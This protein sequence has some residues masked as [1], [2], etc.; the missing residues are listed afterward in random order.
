MGKRL[1][2][3]LGGNAILDKDPTATGQQLAIK[4]TVDFLV[5]LIKEGYQVVVTHGNGPQVG[6]LVLQMEAAVSDKNPVLPLDSA[7]AMTQGSIGYWLQQSFHNT[8][9]DLGLTQ[10]VVSV[11][12]QVVVSK[13]DEA[14]T[15]PTKPIGPFLSEEAAKAAQLAG[16]GIFKADA[17]RGFRKVVASP[18]PTDIVEIESIK[19]LVASNRVVIAAGGGGIPVIESNHHL[20]GVEAVIDKDFASELL[21]YQ[22]EADQFIILTAVDHVSINYGTANQ[23]DLGRISKAE[24][25]RYKDEGQFAPGSMLPK[26]EAVIEFLTHR[27]EATAIITSLNNVSNAIK[28]ISGTIVSDEG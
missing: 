24:L 22:I 21:A 12:T 4:K 8:L 11:V 27:P 3:A 14:F 16:K 26:V 28:G 5:A 19:E 2:V 10:K 9:K 25:N 20:Q 7:V 15:N 17:N 6:N 18:K 13:D 1:V 23:E